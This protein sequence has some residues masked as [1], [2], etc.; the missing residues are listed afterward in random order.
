MVSE[1]RQRNCGAASCNQS[2]T[3]FVLVI[4]LS[5][6]SS[7]LGHFDRHRLNVSSSIYL[8]SPGLSVGSPNYT[9]ARGILEIDYH[10]LVPH[11]IGRCQPK[12]HQRYRHPVGVRTPTDNRV[13]KRP[14]GPRWWKLEYLFLALKRT[15]SRMRILV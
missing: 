15:P 5:N 9:H 11:P 10:V 14:T 12:I 2:F 13:Y 6:V 1:V 3:F 8:H 4:A 7:I